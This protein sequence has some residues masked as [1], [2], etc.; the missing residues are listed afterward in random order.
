MKGCEL[1]FNFRARHKHTRNGPQLEVAVVSVSYC[2]VVTLRQNIDAMR[3]LTL[4]TKDSERLFTELAHCGHRLV[5]KFVILMYR[6][7]VAQ[8]Q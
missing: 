4:S 6:L 7:E 1:N 8:R 3:K 2:K 5:C